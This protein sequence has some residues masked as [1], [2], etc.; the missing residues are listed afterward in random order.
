MAGAPLPLGS[1]DPST[2]AFWCSVLGVGVVAASPR[3]LRRDHIPLIVLVVVV[4]LAYALILHEQ[5]AA[6]PWLA[7]PNPLWSRTAQALDAPIPS[8]VSIA[9]NQP[10]FA[11][12]APL[13]NILAVVCSFLVCI[14]RDR[15][16][17]LLLVIAW[18]GAGYALY[19][20]ATYLTG[21][22]RILW[23][24]KSVY[25]DVLTATFINRNTAAAYFG[26]CAILWL[27]LLTQKIRHRLPR[28][29][30]YW[31]DVPPMFLSRSVFVPFAILLLCIAAMVM[32]NSRG[33]VVVSFMAL[34][35]GFVVFLYRDLSGRGA[36]AAALGLS[37]LVALIVL[38]VL[39]GNVTG[40][41]DVQGLS[42]EGR[43]EV[44]RSTIKMIAD[45]PWFGTGLGTFEWSFPSYRGPNESVWGVWDRAHS[46]P[47]ELASDL[48][49]P[50]AALIGMAWVIVLAVLVRGIRI[51]QRDL[52]IPVA[53]FSVAVL[54]LAHST[55]DFSLQIPGY[56]I[57]VFALVGAGLAQSFPSG[58]KNPGPGQAREDLAAP[59]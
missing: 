36:V 46:T 10:Y 2:I 26:S 38:Q 59:K 51:R 5:L 29:Q 40:R 50:F 58:R 12:G 32:T 18:S 28:G 48:G 33:G 37:A 49:L 54:A 57:V 43:F 19:G 24:E 41:F 56:S 4:I 30:I 42:G 15:A 9:R 53:A 25:R 44:Y 8:S 1:A 35:V 14:D 27:L 39:A 13:A 16:R 31:R 34:I 22:A 52:I 17:Q 45:H 6:R 20:I 11:L 55:I 21:P 23:Y 47:L 7:E 3:K